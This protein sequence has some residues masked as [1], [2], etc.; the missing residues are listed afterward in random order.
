MIFVFEKWSF[1]DLKIGMGF[2]RKYLRM[3]PRFTNCNTAGYS[4]H[5]KS[6]EPVCCKSRDY[7]FKFI[8]KKCSY[9]LSIFP[10]NHI[11]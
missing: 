6:G 9:L 11:C 10:K 5:E 2:K 7:F 3:E 4:P 1:S 8:F